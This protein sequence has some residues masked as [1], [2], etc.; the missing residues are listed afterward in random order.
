MT[1][2]V[3]G[4]GERKDDTMTFVPE[5]T[6]VRFYS[7]VDVDLSSAVALVALADGAGAPAVDTVDATGGAKE[8]YNY[9]LRGEKD[10]RFFAEWV[11]M[12]ARNAAS[13]TWVGGPDNDLP[14]IANNTRLCEAPETCAGTHTCTGVL[15]LLNFE[16]DI[17]ILACRGYFGTPDRQTYGSDQ[18]NVLHTVPSDAASLMLMIADMM[19][20]DM[21]EA[22]AF[23]FGSPGRPGLT[24]GHLALLNTR[25]S[26]RMWAKSRYLRDLALRGDYAQLVDHL[27]KNKDE[28][29]YMAAFVD[30]QPSYRTPIMA[31][32][33][34]KACAKI[35]REKRAY[36][37]LISFVNRMNDS[38]VLRAQLAAQ[39]KGQL[40]E[41]EGQEMV[42]F[43]EGEVENLDD[44]D[45][46]SWEPNGGELAA[47]AAANADCLAKL[48]PG[49]TTMVRVRDKVVLLG[50][51]HRRGALA[52]VSEGDHE[53]GTLTVPLGAFSKN[54]RLVAG[55]ANHQWQV[56]DALNFPGKVR[57]EGVPGGD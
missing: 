23:V 50:S 24:E 42:V 28:L 33:T 25:D 47:I 9:L 38:S 22:E 32:I 16:K 43:E 44:S 40:Q 46:A 35:F 48:S 51:A 7:E 49:K 45:A 31:A 8:V 27:N 36:T 2:I 18:G 34:D 14:V 57:F 56:V 21:A 53:V 4:H 41:V 30:E 3:S 29:K 12:G 26:F 5:G 39:P 10:D 19:D 11:A 37:V 55:I 13:I 17:V 15:G 54:L 52:F 1:R 6:K 20:R